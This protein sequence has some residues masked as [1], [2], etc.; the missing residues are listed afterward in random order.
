MVVV[1]TTYQERVSSMCA[2]GWNL[3]QVHRNN[4]SIPEWSTILSRREH[5]DTD[6]TRHTR[7]HIHTHIYC[8]IFIMVIAMSNGFVSVAFHTNTIFL[9]SYFTMRRRPPKIPRLRHIAGK[10]IN[11][12][13]YLTKYQEKL[14][15]NQMEVE[16]GNMNCIS[17]NLGGNGEMHLRS[18]IAYSWTDRWVKRGRATDATILSLQDIIGEEYRIDGERCITMGTLRCLM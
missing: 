1:N 11:I 2:W 3:L 18:V 15:N 5:I 13:E 10:I 8:I 16:T 6:I 7:I 17:V 14:A 9:C 12:Q 4:S